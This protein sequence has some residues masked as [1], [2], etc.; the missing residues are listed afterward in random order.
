[1]G[2]DEEA[3]DEEESKEAEFADG[4]PAFWAVFSA[5]RAFF[6]SFPDNSFAPVVVTPAVLL[7]FSESIL[8]R[9]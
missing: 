9:S 8:C 2:N 1:M 4:S 3:L 7:L 6:A 5:R